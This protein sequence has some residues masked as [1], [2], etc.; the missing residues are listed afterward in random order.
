MPQSITVIGDSAFNGCSSLTSITIPT[1]VTSVG[2][3]VFDG[4]TGLTSVVWNAKKCGGWTN[5]GKESPFFAVASQIKSFTFGSEVD[6][7]PSYLCYGMSNIPEITILDSVTSIGD[8]VFYGCSKLVT[9]SIPS[10]M[11]YIGRNA[12]G[13]N[14][15]NVVLHPTTPP[16]IEDTGWSRY[17]G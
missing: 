12:L 6:S 13:N 8:S 1:N 5:N 9:I 3:K 17:Q 4:C 2:N 10:T 14:V 15:Q 7:I 16:M 11:K